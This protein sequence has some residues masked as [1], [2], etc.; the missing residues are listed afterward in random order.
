[1]ADT[2]D[3]CVGCREGTPTEG[4]RICPA[5]G[6]AFQGL[7]WEGIDAHWRSKHESLMPYEELW[8]TLCRSHRSGKP[9]VVATTENEL[10]R[11]ARDLAKHIAGKTVRQ[12]WRHRAGELG[13]EFTDGTRLFVDR[14]ENGLELSVS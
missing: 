8:T 7:A 3:K 14:A 6:H 12:V 4:G 11:E 5:C 1:M 9:A 13:I 10:A 2:N